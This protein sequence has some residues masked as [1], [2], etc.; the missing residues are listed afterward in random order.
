VRA[1]VT[2][3]KELNPEITH[4][5]LSEAIIQE[6]FKTYENTCEVGNFVGKI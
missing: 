3:L 4:E 1:R 5:S 6:F 2:N